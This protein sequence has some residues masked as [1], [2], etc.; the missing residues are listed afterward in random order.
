MAH[1]TVGA[2]ENLPEA[3]IAAV[4]EVWRG[5]SDV[6]E[7]RGVE[8]T[9][10]LVVGAAADVV[11][12]EDIAQPGPES[13]D[14][15]PKAVAK[16][17]RWTNLAHGLDAA[18]AQLNTGV[19]WRNVPLFLPAAIAGIAAPQLSQHLVKCGISSKLTHAVVD[20]IHGSYRMDYS[21]FGDTVRFMD[22]IH[23][24]ADPEHVDEDIS[25]EGDSGSMW[26]DPA[27]NQAVALHFAG[28]DGAGPTA[29]YA[30]AHPISAVFAALAIGIPA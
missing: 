21:D 10:G 26:I 24:S 5:P 14:A 16:L 30:L 23:L 15:T 2:R 3:G 27:T 1:A 8:R 9:Q 17:K 7:G 11:R 4:V 12:G 18:I 22:G 19:E 29:D 28:E 20:G 13:S 25:L 6:A